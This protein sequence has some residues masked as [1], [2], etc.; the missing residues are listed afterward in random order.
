[1]LFNMEVNKYSDYYLYLHPSLSKASRV[2]Q[3]VSGGGARVVRHF[4]DFLQLLNL[5]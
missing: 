1:M 2:G 3:S 4:E 5:F